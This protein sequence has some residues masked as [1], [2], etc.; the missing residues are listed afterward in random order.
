MDIMASVGEDDDMS[1]RSSGD[2]EKKE[3]H[4]TDQASE[5]SERPATSTV[6][7]SIVGTGNSSVGTSNVSEGKGSSKSAS[8]KS[9]ESLPHGLAP[10]T[11][12]QEPHICGG[13]SPPESEKSSKKSG[14]S[15][16]SHRSIRVKQVSHNEEQAVD[17]L[18]QF[19]EVWVVRRLDASSRQEALQRL[20]SAVSSLFFCEIEWEPYRGWKCSNCFTWHELSDDDCLHCAVPI[21]RMVSSASSQVSS[22]HMKTVILL[23]INSTHPVV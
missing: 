10:L 4:S 7:A 19:L 21:V 23:L 20:A 3:A 14:K 13:A 22:P 18:C 1:Q 9:V 6:G 12:M 5:S 17:D 16:S 11:E 2:K 15:Q 8:S